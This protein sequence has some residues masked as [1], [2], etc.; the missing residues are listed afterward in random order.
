[1]L[2][3][4]TLS[5]YCFLFPLCPSFGQNASSIAHSFELTQS[6]KAH[7][8][9]SWI[10]KVK[11]GIQQRQYHLKAASKGY[12]WQSQN[13]A[14]DFHITYHPDEVIMQPLSDSGNKDDWHL[15]LKTQGL[16]A[17][18][19]LVQSTSPNAKALVKDS[20]VIF[21]QGLMRIQYLNTEKGL[22]QNFIVEELDSKPETLEVKL[23]SK[24]LNRKQTGQSEIQFKQPGNRESL[25]TYAD[26]N[27]WDA[28]GKTL[29][30][31]FTTNGNAFHIQVEAAN[32]KYPIT[33]DPLSSTPAWTAKGS[34]SYDN[35]GEYVSIVGDVNGDGFDDVAVGAPRFGPFD[36]YGKVYVFHG[37]ANGL[38][39]KADWSA[40]SNQPNTNFGTDVS[41]A[42]DVN[43]DSYDDLIIGEAT[44]TRG[45]GRI[46][47]YHGSS[48]GLSNAPD[49][50]YENNSA[51]LGYRH[52]SAG[53]VNN[54]GYDDII[55]YVGA[56]NNSKKVVYAFYG[57]A[58]GL[59]NAPDQVIK[60]PSKNSS[61]GFS[62]STAKDVNN[63]GFDDVIVGAKRYDDGNKSNVGKT[64]VYYGSSQGLGQTP[65]W[66]AEGESTGNQLGFR[67]SQAGDVN[68]DGYD[69][70]MI[71]AVDPT[72]TE[73]AK[74]KVYLGSSSGLRQTS[75]STVYSEQGKS[76]FG[77]GLS[78]GDI[79]KDG[80]SD[81]VI[82]ESS[83]DNG[84]GRVYVYLGGESQL[85][86]ASEIRDRS[87]NALVGFGVSVSSTG[88]VNGDGYDD[89][90][91]GA[92]NFDQSKGKAYLYR[93]NCK[94]RMPA[95][96]DSLDVKAFTRNPAK[97]TT[98]KYAIKDIN[99][100]D[101]VKWRFPD[102][103]VVKNRQGDTTI[104]VKTAGAGQIC[105]TASYYCGQADTCITIK[106]I[107]GEVTDT[108]GCEGEPLTLSPPY[109]NTERVTWNN[110]KTKPEIQ[111]EKSGT[112][113]YK[114][115]LNDSSIKR[116][117]FNVSFAPKPKVYVGPSQQAF[118]GQIDTILDPET[119]NAQTY[120]WNT[121]DTTKTLYVDEEGQYWLRV[122]SEESC[123]N[124]DTTELKEIAYPESFDSSQITACRERVKLVAGNPGT[125]YQWNTGDTSQTLT[126][127]SDGRYTVKIANQFCTIRDTV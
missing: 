81:I 100:A 44:D 98:R 49:W 68:D 76:N 80:F 16:Y 117:G 25:I 24:G 8:S 22:R 88:D 94:N 17:D 115:V 127:R 33:I 92:W 121:G 113:T 71:S 70:V 119:K 5:L 35:F 43:G 79:N 65:D 7:V 97:D 15:T 1:M 77:I 72:S 73:K 64:Y 6:D 45:T 103:W 46:L 31:K 55:A 59:S 87:N 10:K 51:S 41:A 93:G 50:T 116:G 109:S 48:Q 20:M 111:V 106:P 67:V 28:N 75:F 112:F 58:Q 47:V 122:E 37:S 54:D 118:C 26:L 105:I 62:I 74:V 104:K 40:Q 99:I 102:G 9:E 108:T 114:A 107:D 21:Q 86:R 19:K 12:T 57:S 23:K 36:D 30:A 2:L 14:H 61:F 42:G 38:S 91:V 18:G 120:R 63:D 60:S 32:A 66:T 56:I 53:D 90:L 39:T 110:G 34:N 126:V 69:D 95:K 82:G 3:R 78:A 29:D 52:S 83:F 11:Q 123:A 85:Q 84:K 89:V 101:T 13:L 4:F 125:S 124:A 27:V 96:L